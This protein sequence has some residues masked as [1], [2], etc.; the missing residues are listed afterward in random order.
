MQKIEGSP[1]TL[2]QLLQNTKYTIHY[3]Q[4]EY[5]WQ[6]KQIQELIDDLTDEFL[7]FYKVG[8]ERIAVKN[9]GVYFMGS[10]VLAGRENAII[11]GQQRL[12]SLTLLLLYVRSRLAD[13]GMAIDAVNQMIY[14]ESYGTAS[15]NIAVEDREE[16]LQ[17]IFKGEAF[18]TSS[19]NESVQNLYARY[20]DIIELFPDDIDDSAIPLFADWLCEKVSFIEIATEAEQDAHKVFISMNDRGLS[21]TSAEMLKSY[22]LSEIE[23]DKTREK[24]NGLWKQRMLELKSL[25]KGEEE[26]CIK[27][28]LRAK[29]AQT[30]RD[31][32]K[33]S[34]P[35]D[36]DLIGG[37]FHKWVR[38]H[39]DLLGLKT[40]SDYGEFVKEFDRFAMLYSR[41]RAYEELFDAS[42]PYLFYNAQLS[43]T[44][45]MQLALAP[46]LKSDSLDIADKKFF[47]VSRFIDIYIY[48][49][50]VNY[51]SMDYSTIKHFV[52]NVTK[53]IRN[54]DLETLA[55]ELKAILRSLDFSIESG[56]EAFRLNSY[57]K[58][59]IKHM[60]ARVTDYIERG[61][62]LPGNYCQYVAQATRRTF[63]VEH[64]ITDHYEWYTEEYG[65]KE[66]F[67]SVR[68]SLGNLMLLDKST[69][70]S[71]N[72]DPYPQKLPVYE[73]E[74]GNAYTA[75]LGKQAYEHN[76]KFNAFIS[77]HGYA[78]KPYETYTREAIAERGQLLFE[79]VKDVWDVELMGVQ[80][81]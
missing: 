73:S 15:F 29:Y 80:P 61:C 3:Y 50:A 1:K 57:T 17:A 51:K 76:P 48:T 34:E 36:F 39:D 69:N 25:G 38:D 81:E 62:D 14:S 66:E 27:A 70:A 13:C 54:L 10:V 52:F 45:Q 33:D 8:D 30:I 74:K 16:C 4:R 60:L 72:D 63:E 24:L 44:L 12:S 75:S 40:S 41:V 21:L 28:W 71:I 59:Y 31:N 22:V 32:K 49:R 11:D 77:R 5:M 78:F 43:F 68:N 79:L 46:I 67:V 23:D 18:D 58:K 65:S 19:C 53:R 2:K 20:Q 35:M 7:S 26:D 47:L 6:R 42:Q 9:Y 37:S 55:T 56:W 64:V